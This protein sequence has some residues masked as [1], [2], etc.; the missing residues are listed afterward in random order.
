MT[1]HENPRKLRGIV[2][3]RAEAPAPDDAKAIAAKLNTAFEE[4]KAKNDERLE[5]LAKG[6]AD[7]VLNEQV[8]RINASITELQG[9]LKVLTEQNARLAREASKPRSATV[10][11]LEALAAEV[12]ELQRRAAA[13]EA[14]L[15]SAGAAVRVRA[16]Q[17]VAQVRQ[18]ATKALSAKQEQIVAMR[19]EL[20]AVLE[21]LRA[22]AGGAAQPV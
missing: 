15:T 19:S 18:E 8:D 16:E 5:A 21:Q 6:K 7:A 20:D 4:F 11:Q 10:M 1:M 17:Q 22:V 3:V 14:E 13:R 2:A 9:Q 12:D